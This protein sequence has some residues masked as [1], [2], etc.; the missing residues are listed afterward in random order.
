MT[1][2]AGN[3]QEIFLAKLVGILAGKNQ[4]SLILTGSW[5]EITKKKSWSNPV[6]IPIR[7]KQDSPRI[8]V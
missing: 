7:I 6:G 5:Q 3:D 8:V 2:L 4:E 1:I